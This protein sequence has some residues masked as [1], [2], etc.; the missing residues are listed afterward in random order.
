VKV[1]LALLLQRR[2]TQKADL[3]E[4]EI[5]QGAQKVYPSAPRFAGECGL[6]SA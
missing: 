3:R 1:G 5:W 6:P 2:Q 4:I